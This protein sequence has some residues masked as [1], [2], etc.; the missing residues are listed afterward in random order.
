MVQPE[1]STSV[2]FLL[3][4]TTFSDYVHQEGRNDKIRCAQDAGRKQGVGRTRTGRTGSGKL[5]SSP[6]SE[7]RLRKGDGA[8]AA[9]F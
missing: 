1:G 3:T 5:G 9:W 4:S 6:G 8:A 7:A 2:R